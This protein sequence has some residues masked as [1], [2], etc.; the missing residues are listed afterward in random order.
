[1]PDITI[2][3]ARIHYDIT[4]DGP[5]T[6]FFLHGLLL[7][8]ESWEQQRAFFSGTHRVVTFDLRGQGRS[9]H[10]RN[11]LDLDSL[12]DDA[13]ALIEALHLGP[14]HLVGFSM[15]AFICLRIAARRPDLVRT[16]ML[17]GASA[18][19]EEASNAPRYALM[20]A[21]VTAFGP[22]PIAG[23]LIRILFGDTFLADPARAAELR[24]WRDIVTALPRST[25]RAA[26]A[27]ALR[28]AIWNELYAIVAPTLVISGTEDRPVLPHR[29]KAVAD[30]ITG[31]VFVP[32]PDTGHAVMIERPNL[33]N[34]LLSDWIAA[35]EGHEP[36]ASAQ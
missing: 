11:R 12:A 26:R 19:A 18:D 9:E 8:S 21:L 34:T 5:Q 24:K 10:T 35:E 30:A 22:R 1:M 2:N 16:Q 6:I 29:A 33:T 17:I 25:A 32:V 20:I 27:S 36:C 4:G 13:I 14:C 31:A 3:Q 15:G 28:G 7:A 23:R